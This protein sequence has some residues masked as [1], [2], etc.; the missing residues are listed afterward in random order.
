MQDSSVFF[1]AVSAKSLASC[2]IL[3]ALALRIVLKIL[4]PSWSILSFDRLYSLLWQLMGFSW[5]VK[6]FF[7]LFTVISVSMS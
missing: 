4:E 1:Y 6:P 7:R 3:V 5:K 2:V